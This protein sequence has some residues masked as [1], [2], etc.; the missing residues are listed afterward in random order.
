MVMLFVGC[1][2]KERRSSFGGHRWDNTLR[3]FQI[4]I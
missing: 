1:R 2:E 3:Y 4:F